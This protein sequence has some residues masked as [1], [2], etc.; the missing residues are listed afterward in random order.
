MKR[1]QQGFTLIELMIVVAII[2]ILAA[3]AIP[4][5]NDYTARSQASEGVELMAGGKTPL[6]E[7]FADR[8]TWPAAASS[9]MGTTS[10]KYTASVAGVG[11]A[12]G[13]TYTLTA[14]MKPAGSV[15]SMIAGKTI[16][17][18]TIDGGKR[19]TCKYVSIDPKHVPASCR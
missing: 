16:Q 15:N 9:V 12:G 6:A 1:V 10:G 2:G 19:W 4:A 17:L 11:A 14:T 8:G 18:A 3:F 5:Y 7:Y 13:S